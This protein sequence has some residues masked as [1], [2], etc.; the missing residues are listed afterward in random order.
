MCVQPGVASVY[1]SIVQQ[2]QGTSTFYLKRFKQLKGMSFGQ[3]RRAFNGVVIC[4]YMRKTD[5]RMRAILS[6]G[7][8]DILEENDQL[9]ALAKSGESMLKRF[10]GS[11]KILSWYLHINRRTFRQRDW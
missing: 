1:C 10:Q 9:V 7:E 4:G 5:D 3:V 2:A 6:P 8:T 11:S